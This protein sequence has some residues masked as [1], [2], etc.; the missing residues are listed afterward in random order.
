MNHDF[1]INEYVII[2]LNNIN[3]Y[4]C[5]IIDIII[6]KGTKWRDDILYYAILCYTK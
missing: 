4:H 1:Y 5:I 6:S 3:I 2:V